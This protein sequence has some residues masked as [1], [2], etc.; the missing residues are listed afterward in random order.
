M[1]AAGRWLFT[2][3][4]EEGQP[5][6]A[7]HPST[8]NDDY[9]G[10]TFLVEATRQADLI[11]VDQAQANDRTVTQGAGLIAWILVGLIG[12]YLASRVVNKTGEGLIRDMILG[13]IGASLGASFF[14]RSA[15][16]ARP[17]SICG[18]FS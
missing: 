4:G 15:D 10:V 16:T 8:D 18:A 17:A 1:P 11:V 12:G 3:S 5:L 9:C 7:L 13:I 14:R 6:L 2:R